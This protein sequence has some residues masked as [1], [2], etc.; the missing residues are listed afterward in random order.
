MSWFY[1]LSHTY[2]AQSPLSH[3][4]FCNGFP[5]FASVRGKRRWWRGEKPSVVVINHLLVLSHL[6]PSSFSVPC[7][8]TMPPSTRHTI[9][10]KHRNP[11]ETANPLSIPPHFGLLTLSL[12]SAYILSF[13]SPLL[14]SLEITI[15][16]AHFLLDF[17]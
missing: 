15:I 14:L 8:P 16:F 9:S 6:S 5:C 17:F 10:P 12:S 13:S 2:T 11:L 3:K 4:P 1:T 7:Y